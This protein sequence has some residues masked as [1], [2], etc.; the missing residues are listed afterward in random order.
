[1]KTIFFYDGY[2]GHGDKTYY[3]PFLS[4][5]RQVLLSMKLD[6]T[7]Q[8]RPGCPTQTDRWNCGMFIIMYMDTL[9]KNS[10]VRSTSFSAS[11]MPNY[12]LKL[13]KAIKR[14]TLSN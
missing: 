9:V 2:K 7:T 3:A 6:S 5:T 8:E 12:R 11:E 14:G 1:M 4:L 13:A 10:F